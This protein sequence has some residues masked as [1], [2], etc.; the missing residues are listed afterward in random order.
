MPVQ[1]LGGWEFGPKGCRLRKLDL[2][3]KGLGRYKLDSGV[4]LANLD[5]DISGPGPTILDQ[6]KRTP[7]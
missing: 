7:K 1:G 2:G 6:T 3:Q 5:L 4:I